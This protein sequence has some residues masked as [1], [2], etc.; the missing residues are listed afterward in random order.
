MEKV[1]QN[2]S[3]NSFEIAYIGG[4]L[5]LQPGK[6]RFRSTR[7]VFHWTTNEGSLLKGKTARSHSDISCLFSIVIDASKK[8]DSL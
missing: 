1:N 2:F 3:R 6:H 7:V 5:G 8:K 4:L